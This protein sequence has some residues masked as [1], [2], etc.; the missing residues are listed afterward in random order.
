[1]IHLITGYKGYE[2]IK[3]SD[4]GRFNAAFFG[5]G[6]FVMNIGN[7]ISASITSNNNVRILDGDILMHG[8]H[9][10]INHD[11]YEDVT[12][13]T[14]T[15]G[16]NRI[17]LIVMTYE[18][19]ESDGKEDAYIEVIKGTESDG[20]ATT[21]TYTSGNILEGASKNQMPLYKVNISGVVL[22]SVEK[23]FTVIPTYKDLAEQYAQQF[24]Q[25]CET[26]LGALNILDSSSEILANEL[27]NQIAGALGV[28]QIA[29]S[30]QDSSTAITTSNIGS[31]SVSYASSSGSSNYAN[32]AGSANSVAWGNISGKPSTYT[33]SGHTHDD[34][35]YT[36]S[37]VKSLFNNY[38]YVQ[39]FSGTISSGKCTFSVAKSGYT[40]LG[41]VGY[42]CSYYNAYVIEHRLFD[43]NTVIAEFPPSCDG[44]DFKSYVLYRKNV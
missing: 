41:V 34:M 23:L 4:Q 44:Y 30:K 24:Q 9:I 12:I 22:S 31:Q 5:Q 29:N 16:K 36:E 13:A 15:S 19:N 8:R 32:S 38:L 42:Y 37:E 26:Y 28:K 43:S 2:H 7:N 35:Y 14:G 17:D 40:A 1:M 25:A 39:T 33:P 6:Q 27:A 11:T 10:S 3:S 20:T 18:R 21:P